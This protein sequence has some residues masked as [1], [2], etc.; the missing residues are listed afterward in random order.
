MVFFASW[1]K[2]AALIL[3]GALFLPAEN[4]WFGILRYVLLEAVSAAVLA[5]V[6]FFL[7]RRGENYFESLRGQV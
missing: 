4:F 3:A 5:P 6:V 1:V 7:L 2:A